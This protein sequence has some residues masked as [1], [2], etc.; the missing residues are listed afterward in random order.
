MAVLYSIDRVGRQIEVG[1][2]EMIRFAAF[3][4]LLIPLTA[5]QRYVESKVGP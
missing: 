1:R 3:I 2:T 4:L 5:Q